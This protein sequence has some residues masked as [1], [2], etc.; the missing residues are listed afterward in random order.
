MHLSLEPDVTRLVDEGIVAK[1]WKDNDT[2][3]ICT[4]SVVVFVVPK[5]N[6]R[7]SRAGTT[8]CSRRRHRHP[9]PGLRPAPR[10]EP[11]GGVRLGHRRR[12]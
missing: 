4:Q 5:G 12:R 7:A 2:N 8:W 3:G 6:R 11:A 10:V 9:E 1:D